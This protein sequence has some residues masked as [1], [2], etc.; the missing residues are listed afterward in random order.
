MDSVAPFPLLTYKTRQVIETD[1]S[2]LNHAGAKKHWDKVSES[3]LK[4]PNS[5]HGHGAWEIALV[6]L[7]ETSL[8]PD[9]SG[10]GS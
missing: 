9:S 10:S 4:E 3:S 5:W 7:H 8:T 2:I 1:M 6:H